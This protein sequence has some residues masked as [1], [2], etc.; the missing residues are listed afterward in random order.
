MLPNVIQVEVLAVV[1]DKLLAV[2]SNNHEDA[3]AGGAAVRL[4]DKVLPVRQQS[5]K[6][7]QGRMRG[8]RS[9]DLGG[10]HTDG[11]AQILHPAFAIDHEKARTG[12]EVQ[13]ALGIAP[14]HTQNAQ[15]PQA[16]E[17]CPPGHTVP[18]FRC[19]SRRSSSKRYSSVRR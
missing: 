7:V 17:P 1:A 10:R 14:V 4:D 11:A 5:G 3:S 9:I 16:A 13:D 6:K 15:A 2:A 19:S 18:P 8:Q 12:I